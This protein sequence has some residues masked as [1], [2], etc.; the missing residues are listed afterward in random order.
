M[1]VQTILSKYSNCIYSFFVEGCEVYPDYNSDNDD[2]HSVADYVVDCLVDMAGD[3]GVEIEPD[4]SEELFN[5]LLG[6]LPFS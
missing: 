4:L 6:S 1:T 5:H 3:D 2:A